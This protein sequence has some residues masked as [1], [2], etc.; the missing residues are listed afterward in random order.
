MFHGG[1]AIT[2]DTRV[3]LR[4]RT[5]DAVEA[6]L[7][8]NAAE[9]VGARGFHFYRHED[10]TGYTLTVETSV[11]HAL[12]RFRYTPHTLASVAFQ[13][14]QAEVRR[15]QDLYWTLWLPRHHPADL[16]YN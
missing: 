10:G 14:T 11:R 1:E 2:L 4:W 3:H 5:S 7:W 9:L 15:L 6:A 12:T 8:R 13:G 16:V